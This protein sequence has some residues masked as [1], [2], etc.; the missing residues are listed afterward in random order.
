M[1]LETGRAAIVRV[2]KIPVERPQRNAACFAFVGFTE[3]KLQILDMYARVHYIKLG[4]AQE[5][6]SVL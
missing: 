3:R 5:D 2:N 1:T 6:G 4:N